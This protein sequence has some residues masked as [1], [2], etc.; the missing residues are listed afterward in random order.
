LTRTNTLTPTW[1]RTPRP[2]PTPTPTI[3][4]AL[5][6]TPTQDPNNPMG[7]AD[8]I[9][10]GPAQKLPSALLVYPLIQADT[11]GNPKDTLI[12]IVNMNSSTTYVH[13]AYIDGT[14]CRAIDF[15]VVLT[16]NQPLSWMASTGLRTGAGTAVP[17]FIGTGEM[18]CAVQPLMPDLVFHNALQGRALASSSSPPETIG[19]T[20][21]GFR[22]LIPGDFTG[23]FNLDGVEYE[24]CPDR[25]HFSVLVNQSNTD[26]ELLL[27]PCTENVIFGPTSTQVSLN[28]I[29][30]HEE[31]LSASIPLSCTVRRKFSSISLLQYSSAGTETAHLIVRGASVPVIGLVID[32]FTGLSASSV[33]VNEPY[34]EG[35]RSAVVQLP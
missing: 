26:S 27:V 33:S 20:A 18:K 22:R 24:Q 11:G 35:G 14:S 32:R 6:A 2:S 9:G 28:V 30:E 5:L 3:D 21:I 17:P 4:P 12:E 13:C 31:F 7:L 8:A 25:L 1:T 16:A 19:Y 29:N 15:Q 10:S 23:V 34:L